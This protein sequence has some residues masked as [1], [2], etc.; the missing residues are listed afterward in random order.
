M[1]EAASD[2][3]LPAYKIAA[4]ALAPEDNFLGW[5]DALSPLFDIDL[6]GVGSAQGFR[7]D[8]ATYFMG[9]M[10]L[11][12]GDSTAQNY[13]RTARTIARSGVD[14]FLIQLYTRGGFTGTADGREI[15]VRAGDVCVFDMA[16]DLSTHSPRSSNITFVVPRNLLAPLMTDADVLHG[17]VLTP[18]TPFGGVI[19]DYM[20]SIHARVEDMTFEEAN[21]L[22]ASTISL[23]AACL[24]P[25]VERRKQHAPALAAALLFEIRRHI[26]ANL[27]SSELT[28]AALSRK[29]A[30]SRASLY[31][32][33]EPF[34]GIAKYIRR[35]R[36][37]RSFVEITSSS[38]TRKHIGEIAYNLGFTNES[39][40][41]R[42]FRAA[43]GVT[44]KEARDG[45]GVA[46]KSALEKSGTGKDDDMFA[47]WLREVSR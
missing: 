44:P 41:S 15:E 38:K 33:F 42:A 25:S 13:K 35:R 43:Y 22:A 24:A 28:A 10:V 39:D 37:H 9:P 34:G 36:L 8:F 4:G 30:I 14:P 32:L 19:A 26:D 21:A 27:S 3:K 6:N 11:G 5:R 40:F 45:P 16:R 29:F 31:R 20:R 2:Q 1:G 7:A 46:W 12:T 17:T 23:M 47:Q 18:R